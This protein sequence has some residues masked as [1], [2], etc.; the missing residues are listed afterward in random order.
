MQRKVNKLSN[1]QHFVYLP[2]SWCEMQSEDGWDGKSVNITAASRLIIESH[3][4]KKHLIFCRSPL[5][6]PLGGGGSDLPEYY[7][8]HDEGGMWVSGAIDS[9]LYLIIKSQ[10]EEQSKFVYSQTQYVDDASQFSHSIL[11][12]V[13]TKYNL[14]KHIELVSLA[15]LPSRIGLGSSGAFT[16]G[17]LNAVHAFLNQKFTV[18]EVA[19]E[20][21]EV[22]RLTLNRKTGKQDQYV[23]SFG[24]LRKYRVDQEG[25]VYSTSLKISAV[26]LEK[27][28]LLFYMNQRR[29]VNDATLSLPSSEDQNQIMY[30]G[31][32]SVEALENS[33]FHHYGELV[34]LH[35]M[36]KRKYQ[37]F[38]Y[39]EIVD[40]AKQNGAVGGKLCGKGNGG[41]VLLVCPPENQL[42]VIEAMKKSG[43]Q[44]IPFCFESFGS[45]VY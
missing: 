35:W 11:R 43:L 37:P 13:L 17:L 30:L 24:G 5:R 32:E 8:I 19:E 27:W 20:A 1:G 9:Y 28:L 29:E 2:R 38:V 14:I 21:Y 39:S 36:I 23:A 41:C 12:A 22:E 10:F 6:L 33:D 16:V 7:S 4:N 44:H 3:P 26:D 45:E 34:N 31:K 25:N 15:D 18:E 42:S 40:L